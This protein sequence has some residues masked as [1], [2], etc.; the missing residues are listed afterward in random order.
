M[1]EMFDASIEYADGKFRR[2]LGVVALTV[3]TGVQMIQLTTKDNAGIYIPLAQIRE[4]ELEPVEVDN[5]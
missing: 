2:V 5:G 3:A 4:I 1:T